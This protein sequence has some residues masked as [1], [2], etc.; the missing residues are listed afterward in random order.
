MSPGHATTA[1]VVVLASAWRTYIERSIW[2]LKTRV[3]PQHTDPVPTVTQLLP[4]I[5]LARSSRCC[6]MAA[7]FDRRVALLTSSFQIAFGWVK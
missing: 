5:A 6:I 1:A 4:L 7:E 2:K 3:S